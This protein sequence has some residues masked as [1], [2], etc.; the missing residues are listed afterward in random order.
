MSPLFELR[1][2]LKLAHS[3]DERIELGLGCCSKHLEPAKLI[4]WL[5]LLLKLL[6]VIPFAQARQKYSSAAV[7]INALSIPSLVQSFVTQLVTR[8][9]SE[10]TLISCRG[11]VGAAVNQIHSENEHISRSKIS[12]QP[13]AS[14]S[15]LQ[16]ERVS[17]QPAEPVFIGILVSVSSFQV[18]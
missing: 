13:T 14:Q 16:L 5:P 7:W 4:H 10:T 2:Q 17:T 18:L 6:V 11:V 12:G 8:I 9:G 3:V 15:L 1:R